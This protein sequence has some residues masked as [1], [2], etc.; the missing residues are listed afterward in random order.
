M[1]PYKN[2]TLGWE[3]TRLHT[4]F[5][6]LQIKIEET[7]NDCGYQNSGIIIGEDRLV[8]YVR[9]GE[10]SYT[11]DVEGEEATRNGVL[12]SDALGLKGNCHMWV[13]GDDDEDTAPNAD[14][15]LIWSATTAPTSDDLEDGYI[16][17][18]SNDMTLT[19]T[20]NNVTVQTVSVKAGE[21][22]K[23][24]ASANSNAGG[25]EQFYGAISAS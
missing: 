23:Y 9:K 6:D 8:H 3:V 21:A 11:E 5:G 12:V 2:E 25:W 1:L 14:E 7:L 22:Y 24:D 16:Y 15:F 10:S 17:V 18:F 20:D 4:L 19:V 13:D